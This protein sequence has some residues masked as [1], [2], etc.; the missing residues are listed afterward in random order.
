ML[1][2][3]DGMVEAVKTNDTFESMKWEKRLCLTLGLHETVIL[4]H[5][6]H[7]F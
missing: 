2:I 3:L 5:F 6:Y 4:C 7:W 1:L